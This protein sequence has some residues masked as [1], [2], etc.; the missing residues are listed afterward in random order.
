M[1]LRPYQQAAIDA[2]NAHLTARTDQPCIVIPTGGGKGVLVGKLCA[3]IVERLNGRVIVLTHVKELVEQNATQAAR[4]LPPVLVGVHSAG[5][6]RR[7]LSHPVISAGIQSVYQKACD[8]GRFDFVI[9]DEA[10]LIPPD[11]EGMYRTFL[12]DARTL[13]P[14]LRLIGLT[15][16]P[17]RLKDGPICAPE[18]L[19]NHICYEIGIKE[20]ICDGYLSPL[21]SKAGKTKADTASLHVR[22]GE[23]VPNE[24]E[25]LMDKDDLVRSAC[26]EIE[27]F[28]RD[29]HGCL[30]F[31]SGIK[32]AEHVTAT[33]REL[34]LPGVACIFGHTPDSD[35]DRIIAEFKEGQLKYLVNVGVLT[36]GFD[37]PHIDCIAL[38][39]PTMSAG[40]YYQM[41]GRGFR[42]S[43]GKK[44]CLVLDFA[45][46]VLRHGP[47]DAIDGTNTY[48]HEGGDGVAKAKECPE[49]QQLLALAVG[50][51]PSCG[52]C[53]VTKPVPIKHDAVAATAALLS[54]L[55][56]HF[57]VRRVFYAV[58]TKRD[59]PPDY[60][61]SLRVGY[62]IG[63]NRYQYQYVCF[64]HTGYARGKAEAWWKRRSHAPI[65]SSVA[66][67]LALAERGALA[68]TKSITVRLGSKNSFDEIVGYELGDKP[69]WRESG[70]DEDEAPPVLQ[71][72]AENSPFEP[73]F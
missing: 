64:N 30:I 23:F 40:L 28:T 61:K 5:L 72:A 31:T 53:F 44:D 4:F 43:P 41:V 69:P 29:R 70:A 8:L 33:L 66:E 32:H 10:H 68:P 63:L 6:K 42:L 21:T 18:N 39:R 1:E 55:D 24:V 73:P 15:A 67:A 2:V 37:A 36:T 57:P 50:T 59:A 20:L 27:R 58:H 25:A 7:D 52:Y 17:F 35:R 46:N 34:N 38:L 65:P 12:A 26:A 3:D 14:A 71:G 49:C 51:C 22:G 56:S 62:E 13:N 45:G 11:G 54:G 16:T 19:L 60:P 47:I 9:I 48:D